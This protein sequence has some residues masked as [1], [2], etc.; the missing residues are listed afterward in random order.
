MGCIQSS[1]PLEKYSLQNTQKF[2]PDFTEC[3]C[4][5]VYDG[6]TI[7]VIGIIGKQAYIF[8]VRMY[9]YDSPEIRSNNQQEKNAGLEMKK[10]LEDRILNKILKIIILPDNDKYGRLLAKITDDKGEVNSW[11]LEDKRN[12]PYFGGTKEGF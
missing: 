4:V 12:K 11:M 3:K 9:G 5:K 6:D 10:K 2:K 7:H 8:I 1:N